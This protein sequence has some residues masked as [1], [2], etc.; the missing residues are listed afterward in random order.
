M[1]QPIA[2]QDRSREYIYEADAD[3]KVARHGI[4]LSPALVHLGD[5]KS[6]RSGWE[7]V[8]AST[9]PPREPS[10]E[11]LEVGRLVAWWLGSRGVTP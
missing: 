10:S 7:H 11:A 6:W 3:A 1:I 8:L 9:H 5:F 2:A 4:A